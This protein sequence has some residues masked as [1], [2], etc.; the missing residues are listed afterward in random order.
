MC[1]EYMDEQIYNDCM[2]HHKGVTQTTWDELAK[3]YGYCSGEALRSRFKRIRKKQKQNPEFDYAKEK[4]K[5]PLP[6]IVCFD[7]ETTPMVVYTFGLY[8]E[9]ISPDHIM[10]DSFLLSWS[11]KEV[12]DSAVT[13]DVL[14]DDEVIRMDDYRIVSSIWNY[15]DSADI[16]VGHNIKEFDLKFINS[17]FI[18]H[19]MKPISKKLIVDTLTE[20]RKNFRFSSN[21]LSYINKHLGIKQKIETGG[22]SLWISCM[23]GDSQSLIKMRDYCDADVFAVEELYYKIRPFLSGHPNLGLYMDSKESVCPNCGSSDIIENGIYMTSA[24]KYMSY[25]CSSCGSLSRARRPSTDKNVK[26]LLLRN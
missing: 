2:L 11:A 20:S 8:G 12:N 19:G 6:K 23:R 25:R 10:T 22:M 9:Y 18:Y 14:T 4:N 16:L 13:S 15:L 26:K 7:I 5:Q 1:G 24:N 21:K 3:R 17:R